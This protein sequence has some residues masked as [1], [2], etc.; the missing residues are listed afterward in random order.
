MPSI[1]EVN[2]HEVDEQWRSLE[3]FYER[4]GTLGP[5]C[6]AKGLIYFSELHGVDHATFDDYSDEEFVAMYLQVL[7]TRP[8]PDLAALGDRLVA[9]VGEDNFTRESEPDLDRLVS[10]LHEVGGAVGLRTMVTSPEGT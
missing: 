1:P 4:N 6:L 5:S 7:L 8:D 9:L 3:A 2:E 10:K